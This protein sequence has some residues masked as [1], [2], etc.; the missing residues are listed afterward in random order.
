MNKPI[1]Y[2]RNLSPYVADPETGAVY[3]MNDDEYSAFADDLSARGGKNFS[4]DPILNKLAKVSLKQGANIKDSQVTYINVFDSI[5]LVNNPVSFSFFKNLQSKPEPLANLQVNR[6]EDGKAMAIETIQFKV[7]KFGTP[8]NSGIITDIASILETMDNTENWLNFM[9]LGLGTMSI[10]VS[11][12][13]SIESLELA[14][15]FPQ[16]NPAARWGAIANG[17][18]SATVAEYNRMGYCAIHLPNPIIIAPNQN[19]TVDVN[20]ASYAAVATVGQ[21]RL[22]CTLAGRGVLSKVQGTN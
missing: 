19:F 13:T 12:S 6:F 2:I 4:N 5:D 22:Y 20:T 10:T 16:F 7:V 14:Q 15:Q 17:F 8:P 11:N 18:A 1:A 3:M 9:G 21:Y